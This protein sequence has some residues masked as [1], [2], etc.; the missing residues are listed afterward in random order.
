MN[1]PNRCP[2]PLR[3]PK[4]A[5]AASPPSSGYL[6]E[7][8][9]S[10]TCLY[11]DPLLWMEQHL[12]MLRIYIAPES[13]QERRPHR[14]SCI[15][16]TAHGQADIGTI[17]MITNIREGDGKDIHL[18]RL[19]NSSVQ[20]MQET[21]TMLLFKIEPE[22]TAICRARQGKMTPSLP[23]FYSGKRVADISY[24][25]LIWDAITKILLLCYTNHTVR[26]ALHMGIPRRRCKMGEMFRTQEDV[27]LYDMCMLLVMVQ[28]SAQICNAEAFQ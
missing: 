20:G 27:D 2:T 22:L 24:S 21:L 16:C 11:V 12:S 10:N 1:A 18:G 4:P 23:L 13:Q 14:T 5:V 15:T 28:A 26:Q 9:L 3:C 6:R 8:L 7:A 19:I 17:F 25:L